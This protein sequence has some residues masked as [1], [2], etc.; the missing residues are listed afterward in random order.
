MG[1]GQNSFK[2]LTVWAYQGIMTCASMVRLSA[3]RLGGG[4]A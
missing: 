2:T 1:M 3:S 4:D